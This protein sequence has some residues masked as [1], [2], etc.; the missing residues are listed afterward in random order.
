MSLNRGVRKLSLLE[1]GTWRGVAR[2]ECKMKN[3]SGRGREAGFDFD[4]DFDITGSVDEL[5]F[6]IIFFDFDFSLGALS[7]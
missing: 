1:I 6:F 4:F 5:A 7:F 2:W 3:A